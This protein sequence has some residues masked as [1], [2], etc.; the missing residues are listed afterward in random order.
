VNILQIQ[1]LG[2][3]Y[4]CG[5]DSSDFNGFTESAQ[6]VVYFEGKPQRIGSV[7][8]VTAMTRDELQCIFES[9]SGTSLCDWWMGSEVRR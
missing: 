2:R 3:V 5:V 1:A 9:V 4:K 8:S 6:V 7:L